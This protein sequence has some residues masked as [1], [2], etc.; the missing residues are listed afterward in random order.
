[1]ASVFTC[2]AISIPLLF[3]KIILFNYVHMC[4]HASEHVHVTGQ[5]RGLD[6]LELELHVVCEPPDLMWVLGIKLQEQPML[7]S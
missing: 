6:P 1:V 2:G 4:V 5:K 7:G 3:K